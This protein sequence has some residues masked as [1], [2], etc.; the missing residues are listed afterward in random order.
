MD[1]WSAPN[2]PDPIRRPPGRAPQRPG[3]RGGLRARPGLSRPGGEGEEANGVIERRPRARRWPS[4]RRYRVPRRRGCRD[5]PT[6]APVWPWADR[7]DLRAWIQLPAS[8][9][10]LKSAAAAAANRELAV[11]VAVLQPKPSPRAPPRQREDRPAAARWAGG[12]GTL[13]APAP[14]R[15]RRT[16]NAPHRTLAA[17]PR[18][19]PLLPKT[20]GLVP[21]AEVGDRLHR[22][23]RRCWDRARN[24]GCF[25]PSSRAR[26]IVGQT[27]VRFIIIT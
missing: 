21:R 16:P 6:L 13:G 22:P 7:G 9:R 4:S 24:A 26:T 14:S 25:K 18:A 8:G 1:R 5:G 15:S 10:G 12:R 19:R 11:P 2:L 17:S 20:Q 23:P 27:A 3:R